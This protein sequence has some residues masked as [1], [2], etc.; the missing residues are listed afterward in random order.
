MNRKSPP[1]GDRA[2]SNVQ[3][4]LGAHASGVLVAASRRNGLPKNRLVA[5]RTAAKPQLPPQIRRRRFPNQKPV[6]NPASSGDR[7]QAQ[8]LS[9]VSFATLYPASGIYH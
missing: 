9:S 8:Q 1:E 4:F 5:S 2:R 3:Q 6:P 7:T